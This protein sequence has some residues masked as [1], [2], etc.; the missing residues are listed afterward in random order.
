MKETYYESFK[1]GSK[2]DRET[3]EQIRQSCR[4]NPLLEKK[5]AVCCDTQ[6]GLAFIWYY[7]DDEDYDLAPGEFLVDTDTLTVVN[8]YDVKGYFDRMHER[9]RRAMKG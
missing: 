5:Y 1:L 9:I 6:D 8:Q 2:Y 4:L 7:T 3:W